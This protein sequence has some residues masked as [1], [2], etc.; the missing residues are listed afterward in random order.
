[1]TVQGILKQLSGFPEYSGPGSA[2]CAV[3]R[4]SLF[5]QTKTGPLVLL[6]LHTYVSHCHWQHGQTQGIRAQ[7]G[8]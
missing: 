3:V 7:V 6:C 2:H 4:M 5:I 8:S 1:M